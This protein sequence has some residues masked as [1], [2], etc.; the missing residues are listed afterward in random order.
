MCFQIQAEASQ[1][2]QR[3]ISIQIG[4]PAGS[5]QPAVDF[6]LRRGGGAADALPVP[7]QVPLGV[8]VPLSLPFLGRA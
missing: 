5:R 6:S 3:E 7:L 2:V 8:Q 4:V 1:G